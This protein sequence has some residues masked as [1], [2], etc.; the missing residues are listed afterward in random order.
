ML[1]TPR[2]SGVAAHDANAFEVKGEKDIAKH[3]RENPLPT[4]RFEL[5]P[6]V[7][8]IEHTDVRKQKSVSLAS[9]IH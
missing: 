5:R 4:T 2:S 8:I 7:P 3:R 9:R 1:K 6:C